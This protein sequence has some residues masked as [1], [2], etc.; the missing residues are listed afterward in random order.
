[1]HLYS[2]KIEEVTWQ[3][4]E[5]FCSQKLTENSY[6]DYKADFSKKL[7]RTIAAMANTYGGVI[8]LGVSEDGQSK[9]ISPIAGIELNGAI[10]DRVMNIIVGNISPCAS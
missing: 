9:P 5:E 2:K 3:D 8:L 7:D 4:V 10:E 1:M 6:L